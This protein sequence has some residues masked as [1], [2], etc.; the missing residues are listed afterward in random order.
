M[1]TRL[2][3]TAFVGFLPQFAY[4]S[5][6]VTNDVAVVA[7]SALSAVALGRLLYSLSSNSRDVRRAVL[8]GVFLGLGI[9]SEVSVLAVWAVAMT[10]L[11]LYLFA[12]RRSA[13]RPAWSNLGL[14]ALAS[15]VITT[16]FFVRNW[17]LYGEPTGLAGMD[18]IW[19][20]REPPLTLLET[21]RET[22]QIW[23]STWARFGYGQ[24]PIPTPI[25][26][27]CLS[28]TV[29]ALAS[30]G[31][32]PGQ[33]DPLAASGRRNSRIGSTCQCRC[34]RLSPGQSARSLLAMGSGDT[35]A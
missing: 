2:L 26:I 33:V 16:P 22:P 24:I 13:P 6:S 23:T 3:A 28:L 27:V 7:F 30:S 21:L 25:Y 15:L 19:G 1:T 17:V 10:I 29:V 18:A 14:P 35:V 31:F 12:N 8:L 4:V 32:G 11:A 20:R 9:L 5:S 34:G